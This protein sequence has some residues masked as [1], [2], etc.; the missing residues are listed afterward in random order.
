[1]ISSTL[2]AVILWC[3][4]LLKL[5]AASPIELEPRQTATVYTACTVANRVALTFVRLSLPSSLQ[6]DLADIQ[7]GHRTM[8]HTTI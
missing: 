2:T 8:A 7:V 5:V 1:M 6:L 4:V 3:S